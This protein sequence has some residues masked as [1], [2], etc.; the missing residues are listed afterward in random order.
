M[1]EKLVIVLWVTSALSVAYTGL[2]F[3]QF[4]RSGWIGERIWSGRARWAIRVAILA[5]IAAWVLS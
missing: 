3:V 1:V 2:C 4:M 5:A